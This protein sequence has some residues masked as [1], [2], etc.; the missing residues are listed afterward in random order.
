MR[1][2]AKKDA[3]RLALPD[4]S[5]LNGNPLKQK[6]NSSAAGATGKSA[7]VIRR[8]G[9]KSQP[10]DEKLASKIVEEFHAAGQRGD[11]A[12]FKRLLGQ[13]GAHLSTQVKNQMIAEFKRNANLLR[14]ALKGK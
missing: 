12:A 1:G 6:R 14:D 3:A 9:M 10:R 4:N 11:V 13:Y 7:T 8:L 2:K 5:A